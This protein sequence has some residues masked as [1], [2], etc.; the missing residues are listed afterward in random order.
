MDLGQVIVDRHWEIKFVDC[1][2]WVLLTSSHFQ[3]L[4]LYCTHV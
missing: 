1:F 3:Y 2:V 4:F